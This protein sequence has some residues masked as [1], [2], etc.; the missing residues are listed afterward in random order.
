MKV[1]FFLTSQ[2]SLGPQSIGGDGLALGGHWFNF[3]YFLEHLLCVNVL[4]DRRPIG[5][6]NKLP[7][8][9]VPWESEVENLNI[10]R[11]HSLT[12]ITPVC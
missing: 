7:D 8:R 1:G 9:D 6:C 11:I 10:T 2:L 3:L 5:R 4:Y 12:V